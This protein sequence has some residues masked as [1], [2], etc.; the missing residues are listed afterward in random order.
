MAEDNE[1]HTEENLADPEIETPPESREDELGA[2]FDAANA[3]ETEPTGERARGPDGKFVAKDIAD[4]A[5]EEGAEA[6]IQPD[7]SA[8]VET[9]SGEAQPLDPPASWS[10]TAKAQ[11]PSI[12]PIL[13]AEFLKR[14]VDWQTA[15]GERAN[16]LKGYEPIDAALAP[17]Q[18][19]LNLNGIAP[20]QYVAQVVAVENYLRANPVQGIQW[21]AQRHGVDLSQMT[22][23]ESEVDPAVAPLLQEI[24]TLKSAFTGFAQS[25]ANT[26]QAQIASFIDTFMADPENKYASR[27][28]QQVLA[29]IPGVNALFPNDSPQDRLRKAYD[30]AVRLDDTVQAE[31]VAEKSAA[32]ESKRK[33]EADAKAAKAKRVTATNLS[34]K[35]SGGATPSAHDTREEELGAIYDSLQGAA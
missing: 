14:E 17:V 11:W 6:E 13:Q 3:E 19:F 22:Q 12:D 1:D 15:D 27:L 5:T 7:Q 20:A 25:Q 35:G 31:I 32:V 4:D 34:S 26:Q 8:E 23:A 9:E 24:N 28:E 30:R 18:E 29:E 33:E 10:E 16:K 2:I 21:L